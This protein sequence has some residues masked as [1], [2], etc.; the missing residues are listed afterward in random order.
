MVQCAKILEN[1]Q[2]CKRDAQSGS[3]YCW[4][5]QPKKK[6]AKKIVAKSSPKPVSQKPSSPKQTSVKL[7]SPKKLS[8]KSTRLERVSLPYIE[9]KLLYFSIVPT[10][11]LTLLFMHLTMDELYTLLPQIA[12]DPNFARLFNNSQFWNY[13]WKRDISS[14]VEPNAN[15]PRDIYLLY[16]TII[17]M[18]Y[19]YVEKKSKIL[20]LSTA[21]YDKLLYPIVDT[22]SDYNIALIRA[23]PHEYLPIIKEMINR[24]ADVNK[25]LLHAV[26]AK[27]AKMVEFLLQ[28]GAND[29]YMA[30]QLAE[31]NGSDDILALLDSYQSAR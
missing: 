19:S 30:E 15:T 12:F 2:R 28:N 4:Q 31:R 22:V 29:Y 16:K 1:G 24:G 18:L 21:G 6:V 9:P 14:I 11:L 13:I 25:A 23:I 7:T 20:Y 27:S 8:P 17:S 3:K 10:E 26:S 5:H